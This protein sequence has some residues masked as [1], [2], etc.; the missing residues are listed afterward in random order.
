[1]ASSREGESGTRLTLGLATSVGSGDYPGPPLPGHTPGAV[2]ADLGRRHD[3][4]RPLAHEGKAQAGR[5][6]ATSHIGLVVMYLD[7]GLI[8]P[9]EGRRGQEA[10]GPPGVADTH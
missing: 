9:V 8:R 6:S 1:M 2:N 3:R 10:G 4:V 5:H 7:G